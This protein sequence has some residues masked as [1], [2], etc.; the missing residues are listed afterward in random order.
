MITV[1]RLIPMADKMP[2]AYILLF[3]VVIVGGNGL[4]LPWFT[5]K[6]GNIDH[7]YYAISLPASIVSLLLMFFVDVRFV[8]LGMVA[9]MG[10]VYLINEI[11][12][13]KMLSSHKP[14]RNLLN[15]YNYQAVLKEIANIGP[16]GAGFIRFRLGEISSRIY[17]KDRKEETFFLFDKPLE[18]ESELKTFCRTFVEQNHRSPEAFSEEWALSDQVWHDEKGAFLLL[19]V[20]E[21]D[22]SGRIVYEG[23]REFH[24][25]YVKDSNPYATHTFTK[26]E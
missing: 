21:C 26:V 11:Q 6:Q 12:F 17:G 10:L 1:L 13:K 23:W 3:I 20:F 25:M 7:P 2:F 5:H 8:I 4:F 16:E 14:S 22:Q 24:D 9:P 19:L 15:T 18:N